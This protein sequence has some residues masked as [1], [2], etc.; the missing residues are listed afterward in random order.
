MDV[1]PPWQLGEPRHPEAHFV[2][3]KS[4]SRLKQFSHFTEAH[5]VFGK[6]ASRF[7]QF[8]HFTEA[9]FVFGKLASRTFQLGN[10]ATLCLR[11]WRGS[12]R[13][14]VSFAIVCQSTI[15]ALAT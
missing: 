8:S 13:R 14:G 2:F 4:A 15:R 11:D 10:F 9:H 3:G 5:F 7:I 12:I 1:V 6:L